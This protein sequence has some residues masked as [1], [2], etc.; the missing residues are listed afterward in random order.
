MFAH[1]KAAIEREGAVLIQA[2]R[3][4]GNRWLEKRI[5]FFGAQPLPVD[6]RHKLTQNG[7][8]PGH[9]EIMCHGVREPDPIIRDARSNA[10]AGYW[11]PPGLNIALPLD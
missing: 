4:I 3:L 10:L 9:R 11:K 5:G 6:E 7:I 2:C 8:I 1:G